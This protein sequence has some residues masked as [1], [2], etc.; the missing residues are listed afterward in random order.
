MPDPVGAVAYFSTTSLTLIHGM[1][2]SG[3][4]AGPV[5]G[6]PWL[7]ILYPYASSPR[8]LSSRYCLNA[9]DHADPRTYTS[10]DAAVACATIARLATCSPTV[11][12]VVVT[13]VA[14]SMRTRSRW[15]NR[16]GL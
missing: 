5:T 12:I 11:P 15:K 7:E 13:P 14:G 4:A 1:I 9:A 16:S 8:P 3:F 10:G 6:E 2:C